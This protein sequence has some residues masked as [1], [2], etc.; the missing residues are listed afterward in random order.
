LILRPSCL[1][2]EAKE[3]D[4]DAEIRPEEAEVKFN[5]QEC[6]ATINHVRAYL[7]NRL[8]QGVTLWLIPSSYEFRCRSNSFMAKKS[9]LLSRI[10]QSSIKALE[11]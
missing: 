3:E 7:P 10:E 8:R 4:M 1:E 5:M 11:T 2:E 6:Q 9:Q